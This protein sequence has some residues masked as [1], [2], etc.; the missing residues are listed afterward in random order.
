MKKILIFAIVAVLV[1]GLPLIGKL[2]RGTGGATQ[3]EL[4][5]VERQAIKSSILAS[6]TLAYREEVQ[7]R[8]E[9]I[10][11]ATEVLVEEGDTVKRGDL[12]ISLDTESYV[13]QVEQAEARTRISEI[14][15]ER[16]QL[17]VENLERRYG[18]ALELVETNL[19]DQDSVDNLENNLDMAR[20]DLRSL[21]ES[22]SQARAALAQ[23]EDLLAKT[24][25][26]SPIDGLVIQVDVKAGET[27]IAGTT[28]IPGSTL[29]VIADPSE[30]LVE[31]KVDEA[32]IA[33]V[34]QGQA[35]DIYAAAWPD[36]PLRGVVESIATTARQTAGQR[37]L[38]FLVKILLDDQQD[39]DFRSGMSARADVYTESSDETLSVP[40]QA[41]RYEDP[42]DAKDEDEE[43][44]PYV[45]VMEDGKA[46]RR[47]VKTG[48]SSDIDQEILEGIAE[49]DQVISGPFRVLRNL[50]EGD[51]VEQESDSDD[52]QE[53]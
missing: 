35:A 38:S 4:H 32:D 49:G 48:I 23:S 8:S 29:M 20:V 10:A 6:G 14:A 39:M 52:E 34:R 9:V 37:S 26:E 7:L 5:E 11:Q 30:M 13:A 45:F 51:S 17:A 2:T 12:L 40:I 36:Q 18:N 46:V 16:Q 27:V 3:V 42:I 44:Q 1:V 22:L 33:Q 50:V 28:N 21:E 24:Q 41:V 43:S 47:D 19:V 31:V 53:D 15:I 25:I